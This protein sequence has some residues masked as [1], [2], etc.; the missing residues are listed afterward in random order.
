MLSSGEILHASLGGCWLAVRTDLRSREGGGR[1]G[2]FDVQSTMVLV[3]VVS[4][5]HHSI[6]ILHRSCD[7]LFKS[8]CNYSHANCKNRFMVLEIIYI[9]LDSSTVGDV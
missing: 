8:E 7:V 1:A 9:F 2:N 6:H 5:V 3:L 4:S